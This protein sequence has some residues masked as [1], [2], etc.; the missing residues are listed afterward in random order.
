MPKHPKAKGLSRFRVYIREGLLLFRLRKRLEPGKTSYN[1]SG[2]AKRVSARPGLCVL[3]RCDNPSCINPMH[4]FLGS[5][6]D[7]VATRPIFL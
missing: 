3:H 4:L 5:H 2:Q 7:N 1:T 6:A